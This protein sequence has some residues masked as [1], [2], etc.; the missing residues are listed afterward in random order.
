M[1]D[2]N[3]RELDQ[4]DGKAFYYVSHDIFEP[5]TDK[6]KYDHYQLLLDDS[7]PK[8]VKLK[9]GAQVI[10]KK[11]LDVK[12]GL[13]NGSRGVVIDL[14]TESVTV[15]FVCGR[16]ERIITKVWELT[17]DDAFASRSQLP[18]I[19]GWAMSIHRAQGTTIDYAVVDLGPSI[20]MPGQAYVA[21][22]RVRNLEGLFV[23]ELYVPSIKT[24]QRALKYVKSLKERC[25][26]S[27]KNECGEKGNTSDD[28]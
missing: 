9:K 10:L 3:D 6:A 16:T 14:D 2:Y 13:A 17:D 27:I 4:L 12:G 28:H 25:W 22:S 18:F 20:F 24:N 21:L 5:F 8:S 1:A 15:K 23:K 19:L 26:E 11:N 7:I